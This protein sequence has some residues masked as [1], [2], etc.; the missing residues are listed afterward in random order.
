MDLFNDEIIAYSIGD[1]Q[2]VNFVVDTLGKL[3][4]LTEDF[5]LHSNQGS[6]YT[7]RDFQ[8]IVN[9]KALS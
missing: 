7:S 3:P 9:K 1:I 2:D 5:I 4:A 6:V 8:T